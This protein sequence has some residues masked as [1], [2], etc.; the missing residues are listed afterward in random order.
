M[1]EERYHLNPVSSL[2]S[3]KPDAVA[4][5]KAQPSKVLFAETYNTS[6]AAPLFTII[7]DAQIQIPSLPLD[8]RN[9]FQLC[10]HLDNAETDHPG[11]QS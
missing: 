10:P 9:V 5:K 1:F 4:K 7:S 2:N 3:H 11:I 8:L 6:T